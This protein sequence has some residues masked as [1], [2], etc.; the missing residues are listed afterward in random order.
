MDAF[1]VWE[2]GTAQLG[3]APEEPEMVLGVTDDRL[4]AWR[5]SFLRGRPVEVPA[6][7]PVENLYDVVTTRHGLLTGVSFVTAGGGIIEVEAMRGRALRRLAAEV[8]TVI[9]ERRSA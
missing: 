2:H 7:L 3:F 1:A 4:L 9:D 8:R 5:T 6:S